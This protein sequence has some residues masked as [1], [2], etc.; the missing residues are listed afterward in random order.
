MFNFS[1]STLKGDIFGGLTAAVVA[2]P[3]ALAFGVASGLG[4]IAGLYGAIAVGFFAAIFG[5]TPA[6]VSGPTGPMTVVMAVIVAQHA[7]NLSEALAIVFL[8]GMLQ[9]AFGALKLGRYVSY[10]PYSVVSGFMSGIGVIIILIQTLPF[11]GLPTSEAGP[12][13]AIKTWPAI[14]S[15]LNMH[16]LA[17]GLLALAIMIF[18][19]SRLRAYIP[20]PLAALVVGTLS[21]IFIFSGAPII[22]D[23]P[24][25]LPALSIPQVSLE[26]LAGVVGGAMTLALLGSIDSL[27]TSLVADSI[28]R[29]RHN[30]NRELIGQ[31]IG[32]MVSALIG[33]LPGAGATMRTVVN[34]RAGGRTPI[35]GALHALV[36]LALVMGLGPLAEKIPHA[37]LAGILLKVGWDIIDWG[38]L[39]RVMR[40]P[41]DKVIV[42]FITMGLTVFVDLITAVAVGLILAGFVTAKWQE[43]EQLEGVTRLALP[44]GESPLSQAERKELRKANGDVSIVFLRGSFSYASARELA[45]R[46]GAEA[47]GHK[48]VIYDFTEAGHV[49]TSAALAMEELIE[50]A[51]EEHEACFI[52]GLNGRALSTLKSLGVLEGFAPDHQFAKRADAIKAAVKVALGT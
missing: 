15:A 52:S 24:T 6:Q 38:Y 4:P 51:R 8:G 30:S 13:G 43:Q 23:V 9:I 36:L 40:A 41:R 14:A 18:W 7:G 44:D 19:P 28:T 11:F 20:P 46:V 12:L 50:Q 10:T 3:L 27:L 21:S 49:D 42:M 32:N 34:V 37:A 22:G 47:A 1:L 33:G 2:L 29:T 45:A 35:S 5:G 31:G 26:R 17:I 25:G 48:A 16:A 39:R